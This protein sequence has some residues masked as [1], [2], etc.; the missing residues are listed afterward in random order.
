VSACAACG[1]GNAGG[2][3]PAQYEGIVAGLSSRGVLD[4]DRA[5]AQRV[6][7]IVSDLAAAAPA[8]NQAA[9]AWS[10]EAHVSS[11]PGIDAFCMP[12]GKL[13]IGSAF[14]AGLALDD[15]ELATLI[16]HE[17]GHALAGH[18]RA[19]PSDSVDMD[20]PERMRFA[21]I[22]FEQEAQADEIGMRLAQRAG[23]LPAGMIRFYEKLAAADW[24][25]SFSDTHPPAAAR[26]ARARE[27]V[28]SWKSDARST[29]P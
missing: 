24:H 1:A 28:A 18:R 16:A 12:G 17:M 25:A 27:L 2:N 8:F 21:A 4:D 7:A 20:M 10:W 11:D 14:A 22:A 15:A 23:W 29:P 26:L 9:A 13:L 5:F 6:R 19:A 3:A